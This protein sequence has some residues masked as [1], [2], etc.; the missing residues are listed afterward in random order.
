MSV[1]LQRFSD[2]AGLPKASLNYLARDYAGIKADLIQR[3]D[4]VLPEWKD[5][6]E[7]DFGIAL[8]EL[9][10]SMSDVLSWYQDRI[11]RESF[12]HSAED[13]RSILAHLRLI[14]HELGAQQP[15]V[16]PLQLV[17]PTDLEGGEL[18]VQQGDR[19]VAE[20]SAQ[21]F[22]FLEPTP[23]VLKVAE[24]EALPLHRRAYPL[25][26]FEAGTTTYELE[27]PKILLTGG[28]RLGLQI[29]GAAWSEVELADLTEPESAGQKHF[30]VTQV[31]G[32]TTVHFGGVAQLPAAGDAVVGTYCADQGLVLS[33]TLFV[34]HG[35]TETKVL[36]ASAGTPAQEFP[37][38]AASVLPNTVQLYVDDV[39][40][41]RVDHLVMSEFDD[42]HFAVTLDSEGA[43]SLRFGDGVHGR[44]PNLGA[45]LRVEY[46]TGGG[47]QGNV[48]AGSI[49]AV[50]QAGDAKL[51]DLGAESLIQAHGATGGADR[52]TME[53]ARQLGPAR[54][55]ARERAVT[56]HDY[57]ALLEA[58]FRGA[59][60]QAA[61]T[62]LN[63]VQLSFA[64]RDGA[65]LSEDQVMEYATRI[66]SFLH[67]RRPVGVELDVVQAV[68]TPIHLLCHVRVDHRRFREDVRAEAKAAIAE[69]LDFDRVDFGSRLHVSRFYEALEAIEG[70]ASVTVHAFARSAT[71]STAS[72][73]A[74]LTKAEVDQ[75]L[76]AA[77]TDESSAHF[78][79]NLGQALQAVGAIL[80]PSSGTLA[81]AEDEVPLPGASIVLATG[82]Y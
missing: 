18:T 21:P 76:L 28:Y 43:A 57:R 9:F 35:K 23:R 27:D 80:A 2:D 63:R 32:V 8:I 4:E 25:F 39:L 46:R 66:N 52:E 77:Q 30:A 71:A 22:E 47:V 34:V 55:R 70:L 24:L 1:Q 58:Q 3:I 10:A 53:E 17:L 67:A 56:A 61:H 45:E 78:T 14:G 72:G 65:I 13:P 33:P 75:L 40:W 31:D 51:T 38:E 60:F 50:E 54:F 5:R 64:A 6:T 62:R 7:A 42:E 68:H 44:I 73:E 11:A 36:P 69:L 16:A 12:L 49:S 20:A 48:P 79:A 81:L 82:G 74:V 29:A 19:F 41:Q 15:A 59:K 26:D 37:L